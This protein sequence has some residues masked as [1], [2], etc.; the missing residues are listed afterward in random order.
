MHRIGKTVISLVGVG[1]LVGVLI[2]SAACDQTPSSS[3]QDQNQHQAS[4]QCSTHTSTPVTLTVYYGSEMQKWME[5]VVKDFNTRSI[6]AC[7]GP[8]HVNALPTGSGESMQKILSGTNQ[9]DIWLPA[10]RIW[11]SLLNVQWHKQSGRDT[12][13]VAATSVDSPSLLI[14][15]VVIAMWKSRAQALGWPGKQIGWSDIAKLSTDAQGWGAYDH[16]EWGN[17]QFAHTQPETSNSGLDAVIAEYY[18]SFRK[19]SDLSVA[20]VND[21]GAQNFV[22]GI[23]RSIIY[24]GES[25]GFFANQMCE[26]GTGYL[27]AAVLYESDVV[28][29]NTGKLTSTCPEQVVAIYPNEGTFYSDHP[30]AILQSV[31]NTKKTAA[32][33]FRNFLFEH[34]QQQKGLQ[35]GFRPADLSIPVSA[36]IDSHHG[37][38]AKQPITTLQMPAADVALAILAAWSQLRHRVAVMLLLD[39]SGSMNYQ[40]DGIPKIDAAKQGLKQ[41]IGQLSDSDWVG[42]TTFNTEMQVLTPVT[43]LGPKRQD[44]LQEIDGI[45]ADGGTRLYQSLADQ[46]HELNALSTYYIKSVVVLTHG[47]NTIF[48]PTLAQLLQEITPGST[49]AEGK[50]RVFTIAYGDQSCVDV[51]GLKQVADITG[52]QEYS[53]NPQ[54]VEQV[55]KQISQF[56]GG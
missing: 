43:S 50:V 49:G 17:F 14:T 42:L 3:K 34:D 21:Q 37:V 31:T 30:F 4:I 9:P 25:T 15:P 16:P 48:P 12:D 13:L 8:I 33:A 55:Y 18:A 54:T 23:E 28:E 44:L 41:F 19:T 38:D 27:S 39:T 2:L 1:C 32:L 11:L 36:P 5:G 26:K 56:F 52:G 53:S 46:V 22:T 7:D 10:S 51:D 35:S 45:T 40:V 47:V 6:S 29:M 20:D 24:Y